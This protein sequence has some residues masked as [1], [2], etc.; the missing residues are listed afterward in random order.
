MSEIQKHPETTE[1]WWKEAVVYQIY[2]ASFKDSNGDGWGD[3]NGI[4]SKLSYLKKLGIDAV[5]VCPFYDS[6]QD[7]MGYDIANY[8]KVWPTYGTNDDCFNLIKEAHNLGMKLFVDLVIN[9]CSDEHEWFKESKSSKSNPKRDWFFWRP[10]KGYTKDNKPIPPNNWGSIFGGS[11]WEFDN[12]TKEFYLHLF[13]KGQPDLNWENDECRNAIFDT[14]IGFWLKHGVDGFRI[15]T[16]GLYSKLPGLPDVPISDPKREFQHPDPGSLNGPRIHEFH[17]MM[18][19]YMQ[20]I[21]GPDK[22]IFSVGEVGHASKEVF[23]K[24]T[25]ANRNEISELFVFDHVDVGSSKTFKYNLVPFDLK[26][27]KQALASSFDWINGTDCWSSVFL[28]NHDQPRSVTRFGDDSTEKARTASAKLLATMLVSFTGTLFV[29][30]GQELGC[31]N[32]KAN[33]ISD[34]EDVDANGHYE[35]FTERFGADSKEVRGMIDGLALMSRDHSR[36]PFPWSSEGKYG[37]FGSSKPWFHMNENFKQGINVE[38]EENDPDSV[39][40]FWRKAIA[41]RKQHKDLLVYG[42]DFKFYD[43]DNKKLFAF[44]KKYGDTTLFAALNFSGETLKF[45]LPKGQYSKFF[46]THSD[47]GEKDLLRPWE[48]RLY[49]SKE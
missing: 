24:Y 23:M 18:K 47:G 42:Y 26:E 37:G 7:D 25:G 44:T 11:A 32:F 13:A 20:G 39:L 1:K 41:A 8:E 6:P 48:G 35:E 10:P 3:L 15:D 9:H 27:W 21:V 45:N 31:T 2:P 14:S 4:R 38:D 22:E 16:A 43:L 36:T 5:W 29:Y 40:N 30:Q 19:K 46:G 28:E 49:F 34:Y 17:K 12:S 33:G